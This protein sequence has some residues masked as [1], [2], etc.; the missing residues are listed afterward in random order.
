MVQ[1][2]AVAQ[3]RV[4]HS[5][6]QGLAAGCAHDAVAKGHDKRFVGSK[7]FPSGDRSPGAGGR[8]LAREGKLDAALAIAKVAS[9]RVAVVEVILDCALVA[10]GDEEDL[11]DA[12]DR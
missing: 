10:S 6:Q 11:A 2:G 1:A 5:L 9:C 4:D 8:G 12:G 3:V 7:D